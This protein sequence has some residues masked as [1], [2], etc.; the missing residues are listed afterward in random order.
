M[1]NSYSNF[2][3]WR[4]LMR[5]DYWRVN[6]KACCVS[7]GDIA[8]SAFL[9]PVLSYLICKT[10]CMTISSLRSI[11]FRPAVTAR[12]HQEWAAWIYYQHLDFLCALWVLPDNKGSEVPSGR[13]PGLSQPAPPACLLQG[14]EHSIGKSSFQGSWQP[15]ETLGH[16]VMVAQREAATWQM[17]LRA[18]TGAASLTDMLSLTH[19]FFSPWQAFVHFRDFL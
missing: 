5:L 15:Q 2:L 14:M 1:S 8:T 6:I 12:K 11:Y 7:S 17:E 4:R 10:S 18:P 9:L 13:Q 16:L 3:K 19:L